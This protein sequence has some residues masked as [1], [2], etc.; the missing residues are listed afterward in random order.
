MYIK[1]SLV[2]I[3]N[4]IMIWREY[5][6][7]RLLVLTPDEILSIEVQH[8]DFLSHPFVNVGNP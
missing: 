6:D 3:M 2:P 1:Y 7:P 5:G 4:L 8:I